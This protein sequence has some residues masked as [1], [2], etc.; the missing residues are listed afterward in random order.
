MTDK[1]VDIYELTDIPGIGPISEKKLDDAG[2][3]GKRDVLVAGWI[4]IANVTGM[5]R[6]K[7]EEVVAYCRKVLV[8]AGDQW[9]PEMTALEIYEKR[10]KML[11]ISTSSKALDEMF[12]GGIEPRAI[13]EFAGKFHSGKTQM[14]H[15]LTLTTL[16]DK[17]FIKGEQQPCVLYIDTEDTFR[18][19]RLMEMAIA[20]GVVKDVEE[21][22]KEILPRVIVQRADSTAHLISI[23]KYSSHLIPEL[24]IRMVIIDS[25]AALF[26]QTMQ[27]MGDTGRKFRMMNHMLHALKGIAEVHDIPVIFINQMYDSIDQ[28][29]PGPKAYGG[30]VVA[31][32]MTYRVVLR[33]K[34]K[35]WV[36][37]SE[38]FPDRPIED[39][40]FNITAKGIEDIRKKEKKDA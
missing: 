11:K 23:I 22:K 12:D 31:H 20:R 4:E 9:K 34:S 33:K 14:S 25:A 10:E 30:N 17:R 19:K 27:E 35:C 7:S 29:S 1:K 28:F 37:T 24:N 36:A 39:V 40:E 16:G 6:N 13:T 26:R 38:D 15:N 8:G 21:A 3:C 18:P 5:E 32:A 2:I